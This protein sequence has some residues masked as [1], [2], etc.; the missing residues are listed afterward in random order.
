VNRAIKTDSFL[1]P[2]VEDLIERIARLN[3]EDNA[4]GCLEMW[5]STLDLRTSFW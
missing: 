2:Q 5:I 4:K 1:I 3:H